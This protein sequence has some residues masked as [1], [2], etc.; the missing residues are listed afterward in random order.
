MAFK[1][2]IWYSL[3]G[4]FVNSGLTHFYRQIKVNGIDNIPLNQPVIFA[5]NHQNAFLDPLVISYKMPLQPYFVVRADVFKSTLMANF[6]NSVKMIPIY[7][8]R[9]GFSSL[10]KNDEIMDKIQGLLEKGESVIIF[11]EGSH[12]EE[13]FLR[14]LKKGM[15]RMI[16]NI[17]AKNKDN[18]YPMVVPV[19]IHYRSKFDIPT[20]VCVNFGK[21]INTSNFFDENENP[22]KF[23]AKINAVIYEAL[24][25]EM[26]D[27]GEFD[28][29]TKA[30]LRKRILNENLNADFNEVFKIQKEI[31]NKNKNVAISDKLDLIS[32]YSRF[33]L[34]KSHFLNNKIIQLLFKFLNIFSLILFSP[35][36][37]LKVKI[38]RKI[39][40]P[41]FKPSIKF[42]ISL[43]GFPILFLIYIVVG[44]LLF[45]S[46]QIGCLILLCL[47]CLLLV[48]KKNKEIKLYS[49]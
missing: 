37:F 14:P 36:E 12:A 26:V 34:S 22:Q 49:N 45:E 29:Q 31:F 20:D 32:V 21:P 33:N 3:F 48:Y 7:R 16:H 44:V 24:S 6:F 27:I 10:Q 15:A 23:Y 41:L 46:Y 11:C 17:L 8:I 42:A 38:L 18:V 19:G 35:I 9:D 25:N 28:Y 43:F 1:Y 5:A 30:D 4:K 40:D 39:K 2:S 47:Y 13:D